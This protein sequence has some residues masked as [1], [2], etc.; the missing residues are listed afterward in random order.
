M[1]NDN[2]IYL[3]CDWDD[4]VADITIVAFYEGE[5]HEVGIQ[6]QEFEFEAPERSDD[7]LA[8]FKDVLVQVVENL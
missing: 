8:M 1:Q 2:R 7:K 6:V 3:Q 5:P 4:Q